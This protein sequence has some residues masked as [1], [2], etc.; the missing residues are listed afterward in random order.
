MYN[1]NKDFFKKY[2]A[3]N[4]EHLVAYSKTRYHT[5]HDGIVNERKMN[6][7]YPKKLKYPLK[8]I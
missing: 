3:D 1:K 5:A 7:F 4:T 8:E 6:P 2:Y